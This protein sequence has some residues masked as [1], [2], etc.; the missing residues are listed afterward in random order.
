MGKC[1]R[2]QREKKK[3]RP[4]MGGDDESEIGKG[5]MGTGASGFLEWQ[6][7]SRIEKKVNVMEK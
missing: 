1:G 7:L 2:G 6:N 3:E 4:D 5:E